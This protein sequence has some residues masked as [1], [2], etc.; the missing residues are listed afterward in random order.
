VIGEQSYPLDVEKVGSGVYDFPGNLSC[1][2][3]QFVYDEY[4]QNVSSVLDPQLTGLLPPITTT[5]YVNGIEITGPSG[6]VN[7]TALAHAATPPFNEVTLPNH[8]CSVNYT[9]FGLGYG[10]SELVLWMPESDYNF[11]LPVELVAVDASGRTYTD[12]LVIH[13]MTDYVQFGQDYIDFQKQCG[14][15]AKFNIGRIR[16]VPQG[17]LRGGDPL[18][19]SEITTI[20]REIVAEQ[21]AAVAIDLVRSLVTTY[22]AAPVLKAF[23]PVSSPARRTG[24]TNIS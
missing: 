12:N 20:V 22:G 15:A 10:N 16:T 4:R 7:F 17:V 5:W 14:L 24:G 13:V 21:P 19:P 9:L 1:K 23:A 18:T 8:P 6:I 11:D 2:A 3:Q